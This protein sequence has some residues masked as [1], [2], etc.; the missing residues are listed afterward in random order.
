MATKATKFATPILATLLGLFVVMPGIEE[1]WG[2]EMQLEW[3][4]QKS[5]CNAS[6]RGLCVVDDQVA[7]ASGSGGTVLRTVD[8][9]KNWE[10]VSVQGADELDFRDIHA[11]D[12]EVAVIANAGQPAVFYRTED[13]GQSW[14]QVFQHAHEGAFFDAIAAF[15]SKHLIAMSDPVDDRILLV[16][17]L[18]AGKTWVELDPKRRPAKLRGEAGFAAS[19]SN[20]I[21]QPETGRVLLALGGAEEDQETESSRILV[22]ND[23]A[24]TWTPV[25]VP[26]KRNPSSGIFSITCLPDSLCIAVGGNYLDPEDASSSIAVGHLVQNKWTVPDQ[27]P[28]GYRSGVTFTKIDN[29]TL[30]ICV[31][32]DGTDFSMDQGSRWKALSDEGFHAVKSTTDG[33]IWA[34]GADGRIAKLRVTNNR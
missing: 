23:R 25:E 4:L 10:L 5:G 17:S 2:Q 28:A 24:Q 12:S 6:L 3:N 13:G 27:R 11:F 21:V 14:D 29:A 15:D 20:M 26:M 7:W 9:G 18:D 1:L 32:P 8:G 31:G 16:E 19:G 33:T 22:S 30:V 34:S